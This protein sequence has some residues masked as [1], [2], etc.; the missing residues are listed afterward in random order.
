M[1]Q[2][3]PLPTGRR[4]L[5]VQAVRHEVLLITDAD[6]LLRQPSSSQPR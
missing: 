2:I 1:V 6:A 5:A 4:G 3:A